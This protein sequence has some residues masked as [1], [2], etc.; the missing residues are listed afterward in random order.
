MEACM[1]ELSDVSEQ[2]YSPMMKEQRSA[3]ATNR[4]AVFSREKHDGAQGG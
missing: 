4:E 3:E 1:C 2:L